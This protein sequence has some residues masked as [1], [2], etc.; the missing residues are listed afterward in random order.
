M[1]CA[2]SCLQPTGG[3]GGGDEE[4]VQGTRSAEQPAAQPAAAAAPRGVV[5]SEA[6]LLRYLGQLGVAGQP[7]QGYEYV[8]RCAAVPRIVGMVHSSE[9]GAC[10]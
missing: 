1:G 10:F 7:A 3:G 4:R 9:V 2:Q 5:S 8:T 6:A